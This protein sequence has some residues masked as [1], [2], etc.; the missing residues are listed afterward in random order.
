[1]FV[2]AAGGGA[3]LDEVSSMLLQQP[4]VASTAF[5]VRLGAWGLGKVQE[6]QPS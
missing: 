2:C 6:V 1:M 3:A 5:E 4:L